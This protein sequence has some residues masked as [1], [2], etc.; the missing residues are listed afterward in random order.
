M[1]GGWRLER[2]ERRHPPR[3]VWPMGWDCDLSGGG[4]R[5]LLAFAL[6]EP[7]AVAVHLQDVDVV[8]EPV[9]QRAGQPFRAENF[10][11][12]LKRQIGCDQGGTAF[13]ALAEDFEEQLGSGLRQGH[14]TQF[15]DNQQFVAGQLFLQS[16]QLLL[17][18]GLDQFT[19]Q[20]G[21]RSGAHAMAMLTGG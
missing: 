7:V 1:R 21:G 16:E 3:G 14:E 6:F 18:S 13:V 2:S 9:Q 12:L 8:S 15:I 19:D 20:G 10:G 5:F 11:P 17:V 4:L